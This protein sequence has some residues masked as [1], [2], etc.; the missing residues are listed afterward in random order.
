MCIGYFVLCLEVT[1]VGLVLSPLAI[2][3]TLGSVSVWNVD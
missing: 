1:S 2:C 3:G